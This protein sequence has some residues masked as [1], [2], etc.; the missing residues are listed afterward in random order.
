M[1]LTIEKART[2]LLAMDFQND[3]VDENGAFKDMGF[4]QMAKE[5]DVLGIRPSVCSTRLEGRGSRLSM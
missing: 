1:A 3:I 2:A 4:A 5:M